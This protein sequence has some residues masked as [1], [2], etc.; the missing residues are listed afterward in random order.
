MVS[1]QTLG[2]SF[3]AAECFNR[4]V[5]RAIAAPVKPL[6]GIGV[7]K[8]N[9]CPDGAVMKPSAAGST[10]FKHRGRGGVRVDRGSGAGR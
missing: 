4:E 7:L 2:E 8:G 5:I 1:G 6:S 10:L 9:L 3:A